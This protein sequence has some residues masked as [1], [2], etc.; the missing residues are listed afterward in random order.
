[1][2]VGDRPA[3]DDARR[4]GTCA[5]PLYPTLVDRGLLPGA[6]ERLRRGKTQ[7]GNGCADAQRTNRVQDRGVAGANADHAGPLLSG[8]AVRCGAGGSRVEGSVCCAGTEEVAKEASEPGHNGAAD[9]TAGR[10]SR[11][12]GRSAA[13]TESHVDWLTESSHAG[14]RLGNLRPGGQDL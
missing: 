11:P 4:S 7:T 5:R 8:T 12:E 9:R 3:D 13:G 10:A 6:Q 14:P 1:M 2:A